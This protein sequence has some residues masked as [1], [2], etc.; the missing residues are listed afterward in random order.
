[1]SRTDRGDV[2]TNTEMRSEG[3]SVPASSTGAPDA[4]EGQS[5]ADRWSI[6]N[7]EVRRGAGIKALV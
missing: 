2:G 7:D 5:Q 3:L 4:D 1:M 6:L